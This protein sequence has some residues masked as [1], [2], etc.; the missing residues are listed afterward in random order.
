MVAASF[1]ITGCGQMNIG[2][3]D[4]Q[5]VM[6]ESPQIKAVLEEGAKK[7]EEIRAEAETQL[8]NPDLSDEEKSKAQADIQRKIIGVNQAYAAQLKQKLDESLAGMCKEKEIDVVVDSSKDQPI[9]LHGGIDLTDEVIKK[10][11]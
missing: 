5:R 11:Q 8:S 3:V 7:A 6:E 1:L 10:L 9:I 4:G 2:Y